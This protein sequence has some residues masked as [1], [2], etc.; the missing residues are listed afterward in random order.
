MPVNVDNQLLTVRVTA[1][2]L[3]VILAGLYALADRD[4]AWLRFQPIYPSQGALRGLDA[5]GCLRNEADA[6]E[7]IAARLGKKDAI[8]TIE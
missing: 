8:Y 7:R 6:A 1:A 5:A 4:H 3:R 2:D